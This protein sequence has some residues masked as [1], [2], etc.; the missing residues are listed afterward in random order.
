MNIENHGL[1]NVIMRTSM[2]IGVAFLTGL[3]RMS[4]QGEEDHAATRP[5]LFVLPPIMLRE[6]SGPKPTQPDQALF[7]QS[8]LSVRTEPA[9]VGSTVSY[10]LHSPVIPSSEF[11]TRPPASSNSSGWGYIDR[12]FTPEVIGIGKV[13]VSCPFVTAIKRKNPLRLLSGFGN[14]EGRLAFIFLKVSW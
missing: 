7:K 2:G 9:A 8:T 11:V 5:N 13:S 10:D 12:L 14:D 1:S 6:Q 3:C 4:C